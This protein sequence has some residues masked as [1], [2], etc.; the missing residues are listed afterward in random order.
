MSMEL[1]A[2]CMDVCVCVC[3]H[4]WVGGWIQIEWEVSGQVGMCMHV[5]ICAW[6]CKE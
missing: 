3:A 4:V 2:L 5:H 6:I 1:Y